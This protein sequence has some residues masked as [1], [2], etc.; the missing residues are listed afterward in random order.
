MNVWRMRPVQI[1]VVIIPYTLT[2]QCSSLLSQNKPVYTLLW[3]P[4]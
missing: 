3:A 4:V 1:R 2:P